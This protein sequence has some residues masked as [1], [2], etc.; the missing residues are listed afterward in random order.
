MQS[1]EALWKVKRRKRE[2]EKWQKTLGSNVVMCLNRNR[3]EMCDYLTGNVQD[4]SLHRG[5]LEILERSAC[6]KSGLIKKERGLEGT[7]GAKC[8]LISRLSCYTNSVR[9]PG[10]SSRVHVIYSQ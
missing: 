6:M 2:H 1:L 10:W 4:T 5:L 9:Q 7:C 8:D 3:K